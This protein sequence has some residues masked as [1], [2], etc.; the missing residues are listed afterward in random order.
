M[1]LTDTA[2]RSAKGREKP[3]KLADGGGLYLLVNPD[4]ARYWRL[5]YRFAGKQKTLA[6]GT[7]PITSLADARK[8]RET[9]KEQLA[10]RI[11]P[12]EA[13]RAEKRAARLHS[14]RIFEVVAQE[15]FAAK[16]PGW[17]PSYSDRLLS[18]LEADIYPTLG[19]RPIADIEPPELLEVIR[20][21]EARGAIEL[22]KRE[23]Q[24]VGQI[25]RFAIATGRAKR[26]P[27]QDLRGALK[28]P[29]RQ[30]HHRALPREDLPDFLKAL[31]AYDGEPMTKLALKLM[32]LTFVRTTELR[33]ARWSEFEGLDGPEPLWRIP[34][35]RMKMRFEHLVP[36]SPQAVA[37]LQEL[38]PLAGR[39]PQLFPSP[40]KEG[41]M[42]NNTMLF[43]M[44]RMG[45]HGRATVHGFRGVAS[46][47]LNEAGY[48]PDWIERQLAHD[49]RNEVR[50]AYNS[51]QYLVGRR[52]MMC[53][54][55]D[56]LDGLKGSRSNTGT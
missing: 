27:T 54:W 48:H 49:E 21:V 56:F 1:P 39:S 3:Y 30:K 45:Y 35:E 32:V 2:A 10:A 18:R 7:Y 55:A 25:F 11:D 43:A 41:F 9:A 34:P 40:S 31:D 42:S 24:V 14:S 12:S 44:Y 33:A 51:A 23:M 16:L 38:R 20:K 5:N 46:T 4:G 52:Q 8:S 53:D 19:H 22:A 6:L 47:W 13:R 15:W 29:G 28:S 37:V 50:G 17:V 26:D 36:L